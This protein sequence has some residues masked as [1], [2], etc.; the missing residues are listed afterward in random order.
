MSDLD[1]ENV[2]KRKIEA[3][4]SRTALRTEVHEPFIRKVRIDKG[5]FFPICRKKTWIIVI[6]VLNI[7]LKKQKYLPAE[8]L[9]N[10]DVP[11][12]GGF[13]WKVRGSEA[14]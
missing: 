9:E 6:Y 7:T 11:I 10:R 12:L 4:Q 14:R 8:F 13:S 5:N 1:A 3:V 2:G